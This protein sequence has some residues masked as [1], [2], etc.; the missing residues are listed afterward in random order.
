MSSFTPNKK[1]KM[2]EPSEISHEQAALDIKALNLFS[3]Q[4]AALGKT[5]SLGRCV[6]LLIIGCHVLLGAETTAKLT[7]M[8]VLIYGLRGVGVETCKNLAL[9]GAGTITVLQ[10]TP[11]QHFVG[12]F[13]YL[14]FS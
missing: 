8:K 14:L 10:S 9:Q 7:K 3:R 5:L 4:N 6:K 11:L 12:N 13:L 2:S 1:I